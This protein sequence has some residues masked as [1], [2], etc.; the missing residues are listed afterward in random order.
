[1]PDASTLE[2]PWNTPSHY[3]YRGSA[4][5]VD[6]NLLVLLHGY[7]DTHK[8]LA[9]FGANLR[10]P[11]TAVLALTAPL[12]LPA[13][14]PGFMW[15]PQ[16]TAGA[17]ATA[18]YE[19]LHKLLRTLCDACG[20][21]PSAIHLLGIGQGGDAALGVALAHRPCLG[22]VVSVGQSLSTPPKPA[23][24]AQADLPKGPAVLILLPKH[25]V[26]REGVTETVSITLGAATSCI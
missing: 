25:H 16:H 8:E 4:D 1:M 15:Y 2:P 9:K 21:A 24:G 6:E 26:G 13:G 11:Q 5:G 3:H 12:P 19:G 20:W 22:S 17:A 14:V 7:G 10:L 18:T 23:P